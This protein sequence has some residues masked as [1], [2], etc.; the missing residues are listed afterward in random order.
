MTTPDQPEKAV[1][2]AVEVMRIITEYDHGCPCD[3]CYALR[4]ETLPR[5]A[6]VIADAIEHSKHRGE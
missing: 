4:T 3:E 5:V 1:K 6:K 2:A